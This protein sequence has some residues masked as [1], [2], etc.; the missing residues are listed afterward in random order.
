M[1]SSDLLQFFL[2][3]LDVLQRCFT[4]LETSYTEDSLLG[5]DD[6]KSSST[7]SISSKD[8]NSTTTPSTDPLQ[9]IL[10]QLGAMQGHLLIL[11]TEPSN[12]PASSHEVKL[13]EAARV[14]ELPLVRIL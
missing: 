7:P 10:A 5:S 11:E 9:I 14:Q 1:T 2:A 12:N 13:T 6:K 4:A 8:K 3:R